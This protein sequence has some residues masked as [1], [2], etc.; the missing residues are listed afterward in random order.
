[1]HRPFAWRFALC[2]AFWDLGVVEPA[3]RHREVKRQPPRIV[4]PMLP[5][6]ATFGGSGCGAKPPFT[7]AAFVAPLR[8]PTARSLMATFDFFAFAPA[9]FIV[10]LPWL[11]GWTLQ[12]K[13]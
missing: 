10:C 7:S 2:G 11:I 4:R 3:D 13:A 6:G 9:F 12:G 5:M 8:P 1:M